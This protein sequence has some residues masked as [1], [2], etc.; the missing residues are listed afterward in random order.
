MHRQDILRLLNTYSTPFMD[1]AGH[2][3][4]AKRWVMAHEEIFNREHPIHVTGS[5]WVV[6]P[7]RTRIFM[8][9]HG[10]L[11]QWFQPGGHADGDSDV[12]QVALKETSEESG[13]DPSHIRL[14]SE[15]IFDVDIHTVPATDS[16]PAH[17][18]IDIRFLV[19]AD[20]D[21]PVPGSHESHEVRWIDVYQ[22]SAFSRLRST[23]R[24]IEKTRHLRNIIRNRAAS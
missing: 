19:E 4:R 3:A 6:N 21:L 22:V 15:Q 24:M 9:H 17:D 13:L 16:V 1:E 8:V 11:H 5:A 18:H 10:K 14:L 2:V 23:N 7:D 20:D 12:L